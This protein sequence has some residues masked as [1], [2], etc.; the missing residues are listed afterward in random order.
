M[1]FELQRQIEL[2]KSYPIPYLSY[3][4]LN[5]FQSCPHS[6][7]LTYLTG[8]FNSTGNKYTELGSKLH[9]VFEEQGKR[10]VIES[11][12]LS[13]G[14]AYKMFNKLFMGIDK[15][16]FIDKEDFIKMYNK[17]IQAIDNYY[18]TY[19]DARP[20]FVEKKFLR[21]IAEGLP[22]VKA[23]IDRIEGEADDASTWI[24]SD[25]KTGSSAKS[26]DYLREDLQMGIYC[27]LVFAETGKYP[28]AV[29]F[30]HPV[31]N[32]TQ[33]AIH[34]GDGVYEFTGQRAP[35]VTFSVAETILKIRQIVAEIV[36]AIKNDTFKKI[37]SSWDCKMCWHF[38]SG[39]CKPFD[40][41]QGWADV[42]N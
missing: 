30:I 24:I 21:P 41:V 34:K 35:V 13:K 42:G 11:E 28:K 1:I 37:P 14:Q 18:G 5:T 38:Q 6:Y 16:H 25:Y 10:L 20:L 4:Q 32:K 17:G 7:F 2:A 31:P 40:K 19:E 36:T 27:A 29:Q 9:E 39:A 23:F 8:E 15:K 33:M 12:P 22:P 3:S 26:K